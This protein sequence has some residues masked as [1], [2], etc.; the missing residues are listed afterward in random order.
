LPEESSLDVAQKAVAKKVLNETVRLKPGETV[1]IETWTSGLPFAEEVALQAKMMGGLPLVTCEGE[2][3]YVKG[4]RGSPKEALGKM[5]RHEYSLLAGSDA[6]VFI[7]GPPISG[8]FP[9]ITR[10]EYIDSTSYNGSWYDAAK[11]SGLRGARVTAWYVGND[12]ARLL[13]KKRDA[14]VLHQLKAAGVD[15]RGIRDLA[16]RVAGIMK[17]GAEVSLASGGG[18]LTLRLKG[19]LEIQDGITDETDMAAGENMSYVPPGYVLKEVD[20]ASVD[21]TLRISPSVT[22]FGLVEGEVRY[23]RGEFVGWSLKAGARTKRELEEVLPPKARVPATVIV[24]VNPKMK[25]GFGQD[26]FP[27][28][29]ITVGVGVAGVVRG[30]SLTVDG[31]AVVRE[32]RLA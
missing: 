18:E 29:A 14:V 8:Y 7:P 30:G 4:V 28:G 23:R 1:T 10:Q 5:G 27:S 20:Q 12:L 31:R 16:R 17:D 15:F 25:F 19:E 22:R 9:Q 2:S 21:G 26:R 24:G 3:S 32:G 6:Y 11:K 13:G